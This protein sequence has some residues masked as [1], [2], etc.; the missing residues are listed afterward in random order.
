MKVPELID[1]DVVL[2]EKEIDR[3]ME[4]LPEMRSFVLPGGNDSV[5]FC[6]IG[7]C[8]CR[9]AERLA[10]QLNEEEAIDK[11]VIT[12]LNRLSDYIFALSRLI[13]QKDNALE[14][15]WKPRY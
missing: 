3:M 7:R 6:H 11:L 2:L 14:V 13:S 5:A 8:V 4:T 12:Y 1:S 9:R 15:P 10:V